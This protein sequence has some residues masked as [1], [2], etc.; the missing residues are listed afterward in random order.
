MKYEIKK[1]TSGVT[2]SRGRYVAKV[3]HHNVIDGK[4]IAKEIERN[5][6]LTE[7]DALAAVTEFG[8]LLCQH[9]KDGDIVK[10]PNIGTFKLEMEC[11]P[12]D[13]PKEFRTDQHFKRFQLHVIPESRN[14]RQELYSD[15]KLERSATTS[16]QAA[17]KGEEN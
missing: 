16:S 17:E 14:G 5:S 10:L 11:K 1:S 7:G 4:T 9:L 2:A 3:C 13:D 15:I 12:V 8:N 6:T